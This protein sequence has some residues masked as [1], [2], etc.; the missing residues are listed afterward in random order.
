M[1][2]A[3]CPS[4]SHILCWLQR[5]IRKTY[6]IHKV[7]Y[8]KRCSVQVDYKANFLTV[9]GRRLELMSTI[10]MPTGSLGR[11]GNSRCEHGN[12]RL[13]IADTKSKKLNW[14]DVVVRIKNWLRKNAFVWAR[15]THCDECKFISC[16]E[17]KSVPSWG[18]APGWRESDHQSYRFFF[19]IS[20]KDI[21]YEFLIV[22][23]TVW[24]V[25]YCAV[26]RSF[27]AIFPMF[28]A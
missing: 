17:K 21:I 28:G 4:F 12:F 11:T 18:P 26:R 19:R 2:I 9:C 8:N 10:R 5:I 27:T 3:H 20:S 13:C 14:R 25:L 6:V 23:V 16:E 15:W 24:Y 22:F 1:K 7:L